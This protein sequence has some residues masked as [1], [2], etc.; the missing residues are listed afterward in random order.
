MTDWD[1]VK[2]VTSHAPSDFIGTLGRA[3]TVSADEVVPVSPL[4][5]GLQ[6]MRYEVPHP[7]HH[8]RHIPC[9]AVMLV[10]IVDTYRIQFVC[11]NTEY[12]ANSTPGCT[13]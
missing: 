2:L 9:F 7:S 3:G 12:R 1:G 4:A 13:Y 6:R 8:D 11:I 5:N 10:T